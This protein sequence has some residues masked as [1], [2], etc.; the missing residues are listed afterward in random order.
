MHLLR[1]AAPVIVTSRSGCKWP[2]WPE[3][4]SSSPWLENLTATKANAPHNRKIA[5]LQTD[6]GTCKRSASRERFSFQHQNAEVNEACASHAFALAEH[7]RLSKLNPQVYKAN[8]TT[9][10]IRRPTGLIS[11]GM[12]TRAEKEKKTKKNIKHNSFHFFST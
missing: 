6:N 1:P 11:C 4:K 8:A 10:S 9:R 5:T 12:P 3:P 7:P 2:P